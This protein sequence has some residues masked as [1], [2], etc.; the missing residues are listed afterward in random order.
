VPED[1]DSRRLDALMREEDRRFALA[2]GLFVVAS[3]MSL[4]Y[5]PNPTFGSAGD[6]LSVALWGTAVG[7]GV[8]LARRLLPN[9]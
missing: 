4:L 9:G 6:Y 2:S 1:F 5:F 3:G 8:Q 7:E